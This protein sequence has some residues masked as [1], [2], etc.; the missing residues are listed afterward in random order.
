MPPPRLG[1]EA[2]DDV[3]AAVLAVP[4]LLREVVEQVGEAA[5]DVE[6]R[7]RAHLPHDVRYDLEAD[8][9]ATQLAPAER[10]GR[11]TVLAQAPLVALD[12]V[13]SVS[14]FIPSSHP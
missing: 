4:A 12:V 14:L 5:A 11:M 6:H 2:G 1:K 3:D 10:L 7:G 8:V 9:L 13:R